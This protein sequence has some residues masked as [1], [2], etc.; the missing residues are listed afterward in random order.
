ML[1]W[2]SQDL[3]NSGKAAATS[4]SMSM[5]EPVDAANGNLQSQGGGTLLCNLCLS[6][7]CKLCLQFTKACYIF[8]SGDF[9]V[10]GDL[11]WPPEKVSRERFNFGN[12]TKSPG[13]QFGIMAEVYI[14]IYGSIHH[15]KTQRDLIERY[16][17][18]MVCHI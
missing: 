10:S 4:L 11:G 9:Y 15:P 1:K 18:P 14:Y 5:A 3:I 16:K 12:Y 6:R 13:L 17:F 8:N 2:T 7:H